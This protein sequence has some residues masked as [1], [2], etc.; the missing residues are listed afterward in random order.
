MS[1]ESSFDIDR[2]LAETIVYGYRVRGDT[3]VPRRWIPEQ[4]EQEP[5]LSTHEVHRLILL[6]ALFARDSR[7][8]RSRHSSYQTEDLGARTRAQT[9]H[10]HPS[11][12]PLRRT[13]SQPSIPSDRTS[14]TYY[15][16]PLSP[17]NSLSA[18]QAELPRVRPT[19]V[20]SS[21]TQR[22]FA[23]ALRQKLQSLKSSTKRRITSVFGKFTR[24]PQ[25][26][27]NRSHS[28]TTV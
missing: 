20:S 2:A 15:T 23:G 28:L 17:Q 1:N 7:E 25:Q 4:A 18:L 27:R 5:R 16:A 13:Q 14:R 26:P 3:T 22:T 8:R 19:R 11:A 6:P 12:A 10:S 21:T 24:K 9:R